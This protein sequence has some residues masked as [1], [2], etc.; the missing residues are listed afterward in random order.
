MV[1]AADDV[2]ELA[3]GEIDFVAAR[4]EEV[5][6]VAVVV[7]GADA[8]SDGAARKRL[9]DER[10]RVGDDGVRRGG[11]AIRAGDVVEIQG[12]DRAGGILVSEEAVAG[13][14]GK[15]GELGVPL[16]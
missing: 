8:G 2:V 15:D 16:I 4:R 11:V 6:V 5:E 3:G 1:F 10:E 7:I 13:A 9:V 12:T 14:I